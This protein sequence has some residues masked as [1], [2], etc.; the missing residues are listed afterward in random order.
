[1]PLEAILFRCSFFSYKVEKLN[2]V[3]F[4]FFVTAE[5]IDMDSS[6]RQRHKKKN[7][8]EKNY[9]YEIFSYAKSSILLLSFLLL[10]NENLH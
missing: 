2:I 4:P 6:F 10:R 7:Q 9:E 8:R 1:M 3:P 5:E